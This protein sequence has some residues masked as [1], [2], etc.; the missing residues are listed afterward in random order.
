[1]QWSQFGDI[2]YA[3]VIKLEDHGGRNSGRFIILYGAEVTAAIK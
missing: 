1:M 3:E 2:C